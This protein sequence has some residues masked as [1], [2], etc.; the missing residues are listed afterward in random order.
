MK[1]KLIGF[2][3][4]WIKAIQQYANENHNGNFTEAVRELSKLG[5]KAKA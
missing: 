2:E 5:F 1:Y 3:V 4:E